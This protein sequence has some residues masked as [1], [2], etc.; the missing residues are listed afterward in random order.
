MKENE[1]P[2]CTVGYLVRGQ[3]EN[4]EVFL[5]TKAAT[6]KAIKRKIAGKLIGFGGD[7]EPEKDRSIKESF[8]RELKEEKG[9]D[10]KPHDMTIVARVLIVDEGGPRLILYYLLVWEWEGV[11]VDNGEIIG[12]DWYGINPLP[13]NILEADKLILPR[14]LRGTNLQGFVEYDAD[15]KVVRH[16]LTP[17]GSIE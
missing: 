7:F 8:A 5:G 3:G 11:P 2:V 14:V 17:V 13:E 16:E 9:Y 4:L 12:G 10:V 15:M 6:P 1:L